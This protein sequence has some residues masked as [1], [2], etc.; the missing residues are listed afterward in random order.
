MAISQDPILHFENDDGSPLVGGFLTTLVGGIN[1]PTYSENTGTFALPNPIVLNSRGEVATNAGTSSPLF[2]SPNVAY[3][4]IL[5]RPDL[6]TVWAAPNIVCAATTA[7]VLAALTQN[8]IGGILFPIT[9]IEIAAGVTPTVFYYPQGDIRRYGAVL[10]GVTNDTGAAQ[11]WLNVGG[12]LTFPVAQTALITGPIAPRSNTTIT[13]CDGATFQTATHDICMMLATGSTNITIKGL[14]FEQTSVGIAAN[15]AGILF[16]A[17]T[18]CTVELCEFIGMQCCGIRAIASSNCTF[19]NNYIHD[20]LSNPVIQSSADIAIESTP[21]APSSYNIVDGNQCFGAAEFGISCWDPYAGF[22]PLKN[23]IT[24]NRVGAHRGYGILV[25]MPFAGDSFNQVMNNDVQDINAYDGASPNNSSG[26]GIYVQGAG[27][28]GTQVIGNSI[29]N[30]CL[31]T[32]NTTLAPA[33]IGVNS[34][35][36]ATTPIIIANNTI[37]NMT[38]YFGI[39]VTGM[40]GG[41]SITGNV[42]RMPASNIT[43]DGIRIVNSNNVSC[44]SNIILNNNTTTNQICISVW[45]QGAACSNIVIA[46]NTLNGGFLA[47]LRTIQTLGNV[48]TGLV[49]NGN[50]MTGGGAGC[51]PLTLDGTSAQNVLIS[52]NNIRANTVAAISQN[53]CTSVR[54]T[55]NFV[56]SSGAVTLSFSG[57][58]TSGFYDKSNVGSGAGAAISNTGTGLIIEQFGTAVPAA[59]TWA[60]GDTVINSAPSAAGVSF[61]RCTVAGTPGTFKT[62]SNT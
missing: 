38:Q 14:H 42:M 62:I 5:Q 16:N 13:A 6:T 9:Q 57:A 30:C 21:A 55:N 1:F 33:A 27:A 3:T 29:R 49:I 11:S 25:Y 44:S 10:D 15:L 47:Q 39:L 59:G 48:I 35:S 56:V 60:V 32:A 61:W 50:M 17:C 31:G 26:A 18:N 7:S 40:L 51:I 52:N 23:L 20:G 34:T 43:G 46:N 22:S 58:N 54:Y 12:A 4:F 19:H 41:G 24:G 36:N 37:D 53:A 8:I 2:L 28:G 45:A